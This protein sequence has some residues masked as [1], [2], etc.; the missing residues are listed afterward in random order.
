MRTFYGKY[1]GQVVSSLD[2]ERRGRVQVRVPAVYGDGSLAW[3]EPCAPY[4]GPGVGLLLLP[5]DGANVW[6]EFEAGDPDAPIWSGCFW[7]RGELPQQATSPARKV[8]R[9][10]QVTIVVED[11]AGG[12]ITLETDQGMRV[13]LRPG[14][15]EI[16]NGSASIALEGPKVA[17]NDDGLEV[18]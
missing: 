12:T 3:A 5:P 11:E 18:T 13:A 9:T 8:L 6:V 2:P 17:V 4:A 14:G 7:G 10:D 16:T 1:R 15:I